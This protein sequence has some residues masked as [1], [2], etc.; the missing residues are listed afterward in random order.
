MSLS[1][2]QRREGVLAEIGGDFPMDVAVIESEL[3]GFADETES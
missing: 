3:N 1:I 2:A